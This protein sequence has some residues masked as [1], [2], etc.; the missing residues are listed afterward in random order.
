LSLQLSR[1]PIACDSSPGASL[2]A[3]PAALTNFVSLLELSI[4]L[5]PFY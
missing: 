2:A 5:S 3:Q 1:A 4:L